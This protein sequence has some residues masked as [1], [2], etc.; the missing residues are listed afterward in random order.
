MFSLHCTI[1][2]QYKCKQYFVKQVTL[3]GLHTQ[4]M[5]A[6]QEVKKVHVVDAIPT[7]E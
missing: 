5:E 2:I 6:K 7:E 4:V 3:R 1:Q